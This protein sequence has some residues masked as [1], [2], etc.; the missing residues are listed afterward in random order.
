[1][2]SKLSGTKTD[3]N[4]R[5]AFSG[6][7]EA[8]NKYTY[9]AGVARK[10]GYEQIAAIFDETANN[11][12]EHAEIWFKELQGIGNT[13]QNLKSAAAGEHYEWSD[14]YARFAAEAR[15]EGFTDI[16]L[17]FEQ[18]ANIEKDHEERYLTLLKN[19]QENHV[20]SKDGEI[21][22]IC[23]NCGFSF[24]GTDAPEECPVCSHKQS[25]FQEKAENYH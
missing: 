12:K 1:M 13:E 22:W 8:R 17:K 20:F 24:V 6:E 7:S 21:R 16:A 23:R 18:V 10:E 2:S 11:E 4:L 14:M 19:T 5:N 9:F 25:Y 15:E 3:Q